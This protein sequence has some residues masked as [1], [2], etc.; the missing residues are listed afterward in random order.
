MNSVVLQFAHNAAL[1][2]GYGVGGS[3]D[4]RREWMV[5]DHWL[6]E[7]AHSKWSATST[8]GYRHAKVNDVKMREMWVG[9]RPLY[10]INEVLG[11]FSELS[12]QRVKQDSQ[13]TR[14]LSKVTLGTQFSMGPGIMAR[15]AL[16]LFAT[17]AK[18]NDAAANAGPVACTGRDCNTAVTSFANK[19][20]AVT[21]G[22]QVEAWF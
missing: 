6:Y 12:H 18:W 7:P 9:T 5:F 11:L 22:A 1:L 4:K 8:I 15:P 21:F 17:Y 19:R 2:K 20:S 3:T 16:R 13:S 10:N 14:T